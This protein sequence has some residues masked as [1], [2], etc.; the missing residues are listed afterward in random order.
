M[1][2]SELKIEYMRGTGAG[3]QRKNKVAT[4]C[5]IT[6]IPSGLSAYSDQ[7]MQKDSR[8]SAMKDLLKKLGLRKDAKRAEAKKK[9]RD[10]AIH[11]EERI[12]TYDFKKGIVIDHRTGKKA[13]L[14]EVLG[15]GRIDLL[16]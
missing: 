14:K 8:K 13:S 3:G 6:H 10:H 11:N 16:R 12:R 1:N 4:A 2:K 5:R 7:R 15:K 9:R